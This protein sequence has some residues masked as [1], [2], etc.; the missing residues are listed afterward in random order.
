MAYTVQEAAQ[1]YRKNTEMNLLL[2]LL[3]RGTINHYRQSDEI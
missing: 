2:R 1:S 3:F